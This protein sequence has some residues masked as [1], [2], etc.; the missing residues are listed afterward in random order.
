MKRLPTGYANCFKEAFRKRGIPILIVTG[1]IAAKVAGIAIAI[2]LVLCV[3][4]LWVSAI[5]TAIVAFLCP[6]IKKTR[7]N[8]E[9][10]RNMDLSRLEREADALKWAH[11]NKRFDGNHM[12]R[13]RGALVNLR[14]AEARWG[15]FNPRLKKIKE[16]YKTLENLYLK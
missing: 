5:L 10:E 9:Y 1:S 2:Y 16:E 14:N 11:V 6:V 12:R 3:F 15:S 13:L 4:P 7:E 8:V